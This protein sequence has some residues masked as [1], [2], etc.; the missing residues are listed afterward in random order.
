MEL[1]SVPFEGLV[2]F[3]PDLFY[4]DRGYFFESYQQLKLEKLG[5]K[6][7]FVQDNQSRSK[8]GVV[9]G[10]HFQK[11]PYAQA[12]LVRVVQGEILDVAVDLRKGSPNYGTYFAVHL[13]AENF[14]QFYIP[15]GFA[16]GFSALADDTI[17]QYKCSSFYHKEAEGTIIYND[18][19]LN[20]DWKVDA[21]IVTSK[22]MEGE[23]FNHFKTPF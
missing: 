22:D 5:I 9:R 6:H 2:L 23:Q 3:K 1:L 20:I 21:P 10:L 13:S 16:H 19:T 18:P 7:P 12:K 11:P 4:D 15:V 8:K 17:V 14:L